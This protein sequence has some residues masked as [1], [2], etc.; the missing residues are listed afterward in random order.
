MQFAYKGAAADARPFHRAD[1]HRQAGVCRSCQTLK[2]RYLE[3]GN[4][5]TIVRNGQILL[6]NIEYTDWLTY[7]SRPVPDLC[8]GNVYYVASL[9]G[10]YTF[11]VFRPKL[12]CASGG[13]E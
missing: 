6:K 5:A 10:C 4:A 7:R 8:L 13:R 2:V 11:R 12:H 1:S 9:G 3:N